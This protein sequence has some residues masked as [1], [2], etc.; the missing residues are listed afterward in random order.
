MK[1]TIG[2]TLLVMIPLSISFLLY[3]FDLPKNHR[4]Y[5]VH[6]FIDTVEITGKHVPDNLYGLTFNLVYQDSTSQIQKIKKV[7]YQEYNLSEVNTEQVITYT[8]D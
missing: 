7:S 6:K 8:I 4:G 1:R 3:S 5:L 2:L